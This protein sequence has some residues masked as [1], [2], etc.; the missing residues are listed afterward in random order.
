M[1]PLDHR[2][3]GIV[4]T[5]L[6]RDDVYPE[7]ICDGVHVDPA[8]IRLWLKIKGAEHAILVTDGISATGMPDGPYR[9]GDFDVEVKNGVCLFGETLAGSVLT[10]N[11]AVANVQ[12]FTGTSLGT[13]V[14]LA[15]RNPARMMGMSHLSAMAP[16]TPAN[17]NVF[18]QAG[19]RT[20]SILHGRLIEYS[21]RRHPHSLPASPTLNRNAIGTSSA[22]K[23]YRFVYAVFECCSNADRRLDLARG[24]IVR[25]RVEPRLP[26]LVPAQ[27]K[28]HQVR[29]AEQDDDKAMLIPERVRE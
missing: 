9:L 5:I 21:L 24:N 26:N 13:A 6:N 10:M 3:L 16:G 28:V 8:I 7:A 12:R 4:G 15:S 25:K 1:R 27:R 19:A 22:S 20:G 11:Q 23:R 29:I 17:F 18:D 2:E 14:R